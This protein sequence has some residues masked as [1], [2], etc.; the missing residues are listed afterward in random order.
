MELAYA[1]LMTENEEL[2]QQT[3]EAISAI[4]VLAFSDDIRKFQAIYQSV[5]ADIRQMLEGMDYFDRLFNDRKLLEAIRM[6]DATS[7]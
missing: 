4:K 2:Q 5:P 6:V 3:R 7:S 1:I